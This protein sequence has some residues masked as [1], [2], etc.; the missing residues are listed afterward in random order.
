MILWELQKSYLLMTRA[1]GRMACDKYY[2]QDPERLTELLAQA[3]Q[4]LWRIDISDCPLDWRL[5]RKLEVA[6]FYVENQHLHR[7]G[8]EIQFYRSRKNGRVR[9]VAGYCLVLSKLTA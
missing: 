9:Q 7:K 6:R 5:D 1:T 2:M 3:L 4:E 8:R